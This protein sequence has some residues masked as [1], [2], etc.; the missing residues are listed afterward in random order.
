LRFRSRFPI[1][2]KSEDLVEKI[3]EY[4]K[5]EMADIII[6]VTGI[7]KIVNIC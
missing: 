3:K 1:N 5:D 2:T 7:S 6:G 4:T